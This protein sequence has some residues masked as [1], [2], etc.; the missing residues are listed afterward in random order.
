MSLSTL[1]PFTP[2]LLLQLLQRHLTSTQSTPSR[3]SSP[4]DPNNQTPWSTALPS[5]ILF[6]DVSGFTSLTES[7]ASSGGSGLE[8]LTHSLNSYFSSILLQIESHQGDLLKVAGDALIVAFYNWTDKAVEETKDP[9]PLLCHRA[10]S[11]ALAL[12]AAPTFTAGGVTLG[13]HIGVT[14]GVTRYIGVGG[15]EQ[16]WGTGSGTVT[17][18]EMEANAPLTTAAEGRG[19]LHLGVRSPQTPHIF[20]S[21]HLSHTRPLLPT[22]LRVPHQGQRWPVRSVIPAPSLPVADEAAVHCGGAGALP[23]ARSW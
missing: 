20:P 14:S 7:F 19:A 22:A 2:S 3:P 15:T 12:Q 11:C 18:I 17:P 21:G 1:T 4:L 23:C 10:V 9:L 5:S 6:I 16:Q 13:M 8:Q